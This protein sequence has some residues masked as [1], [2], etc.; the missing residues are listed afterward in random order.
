MIAGLIFS[1]LSSSSVFNLTLCEYTVILP[2]FKVG[3]IISL[4]QDVLRLTPG[5][6]VETDGYISVV[7]HLEQDEDE[8]ES[9]K[10]SSDN[11]PP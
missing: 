9:L 4:V 10:E 7:Q 1:E 5:S 6:A 2:D 8:D 3:E 11:L